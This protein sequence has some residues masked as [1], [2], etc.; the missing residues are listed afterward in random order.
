MSDDATST[1]DTP[2]KNLRVSEWTP[3]AH[4]DMNLRAYRAAIVAFVVAVVGGLLAALSYW[5]SWADTWLGVGLALALGGI[6]FGL[7]SWSKYL[8]LDD[9]VVQMREPLH[10]TV[11]EQHDLEEEIEMTKNTVGRRKLLVGLLGGSF[12]SLAVGFVGPIGSLGPKPQGERNSTGWSAGRRV[13]TNDSVPIQ[14]STGQ[15]DQ[16]TT[17]FPEGFVGRDD[18]Q[19]VLLR[20]HPDILS[21]QTVAQGAIDG[22]V[23]YSKVCTHAGC[24]VG[25]FGIDTREPD[26]VRQLV[27]PCHQSVFDPTDAARPVG[28]PAP[29]PLPQLSLGVDDEGYLIANG[30]FERPVGP[31]SWTEGWTGGW[32]GQ[33]Q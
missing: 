6:G 22:W 20:M 5:N 16:L 27:C 30:D 19:I 29:R 18:S 12:A 21:E 24:S 32:T 17:A 14:L 26:V 11:Q 15:F 9:H 7:V 3:V 23:A 4:E 10:T 8:D 31:I 28:G 2:I 1:D 33:D 13:V 25:L